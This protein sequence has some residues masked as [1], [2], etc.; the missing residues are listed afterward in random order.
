MS[1]STPVLKFVCVK[2]RPLYD[3]RHVNRIQAMLS[4]HS[5]LDIQ[6]TCLTDD[7]HGIDDDIEIVKLEHPELT[8]WW[9]KMQIFQWSQTQNHP[10]CYIDL[11]TA[12]VGNIDPLATYTGDFAILSDF[13]LHK[14]NYQSSV[15]LFKGGFG[16]E[17][18]E[19]FFQ[20]T[21]QAT[22]D[23][24]PNVAPRPGKWGDQYYI[25]RYVH[26]ADYLQDLF[27]GMLLSFKT[28]IAERGHIPHGASII[29]YHGTPRPFHY[30]GK[31][32]H[33]WRVL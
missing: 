15:M 7:P 13:Y 19:R 27:P 5:T 31:I 30:D 3:A 24:A 17:L 4:L 25:E 10:I 1:K 9:H 11:D 2:A 33:E 29:C 32:A 26:N 16:K 12:I 6:L 20:D 14:P 18:A 23:H 28:D 21:K 8:G 22:R